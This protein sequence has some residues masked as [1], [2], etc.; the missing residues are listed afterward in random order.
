MT[1]YTFV[2]PQKDQKVENEEE[3]VIIYDFGDLCD[4]FDNMSLSPSDFWCYH[5]TLEG[6]PVSEVPA[7]I[8]LEYVAWE[9]PNA[10]VTFSV[11][12]QEPGYKDYLE[13]M[14]S[15]PGATIT[16]MTRGGSFPCNVYLCSFPTSPTL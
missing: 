14:E 11:T 8:L 9:E 3:E 2:S 5:W 6:I 7:H 10:I 1:K 15:Y 12:S 13:I 16:T 4:H